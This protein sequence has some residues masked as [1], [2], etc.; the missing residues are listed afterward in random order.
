MIQNRKCKREYCPEIL[1]KGCH[2]SVKKFNERRYCSR[3]CFNIDKATE[4]IKKRAGIK[5]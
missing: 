1:V 4:G 3:R 2:E 5:I